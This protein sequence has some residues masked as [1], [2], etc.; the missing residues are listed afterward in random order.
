[1]WAPWEAD[2]HLNINLQMNYW[3]ADLCNLSETVDPLT[4]WF[5]RLTKKGQMTAQKLYESDG[6]VAYLS[7]NPFGR[8]TPAGSTQ[9]SQFQNSVLD[10]LAGAWTAMTLW[11][12]YEFTQD[13]A[14]LK[15][16]AYPVLKGA[17][18]F[19]LDYLDRGPG[20]LPGHCSFHLAGKSVYPSGNQEGRANH[21]RIDVPHDPG[22]RSF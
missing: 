19:I 3:P 6:W 16:R 15:D 18:Q 1:M 13:E 17:A 2:Y 22:A 14:F 8:T 7:T 12:H 11:R 10:P 21:E 9:S 5:S 20:R 4:D